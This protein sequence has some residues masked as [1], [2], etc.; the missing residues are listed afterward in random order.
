MK[1]YRI[2]TTAIALLLT[3]RVFAATDT[4]DGGGPDNNISTNNN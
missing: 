1:N 2:V 4:W 3:A